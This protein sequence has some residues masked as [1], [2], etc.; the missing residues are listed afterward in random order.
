MSIPIENDYLREMRDMMRSQLSSLSSVVLERTSKGT[1]VAVKGFGT[2]LEAVARMVE[3]EY[4]RLM[5]KYS[6]E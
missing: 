4:D 2:D 1:N 3:Q 6:A 5:G